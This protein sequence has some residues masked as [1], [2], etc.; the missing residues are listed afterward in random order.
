MKKLHSLL[1]FVAAAL[2]GLIQFAPL[3]AA[4]RCTVSDIEAWW[5]EAGRTVPSLAAVPQDANCSTSAPAWFNRFAAL[6][7]SQPV[8]S[9]SPNFSFAE[10]NIMTAFAV[11]N[12]EAY[13]R[14]GQTIQVC[15]TPGYEV[16][17]DTVVRYASEWEKYANIRFDFKRVGDC[18]PKGSDIRVSLEP[19]GSSWSYIGTSSAYWAR[20]GQITL[21]L[22]WLANP[23]QDAAWQRATIIHEFGHA[24]GLHHEQQN[25]NVKI[26][27]DPYKAYIYFARTNGW[28]PTD[29]DINVLN[30][31]KENVDATLWDEKSI[32]HYPISSWVTTNGFSVG[33]NTQLSEGDMLWAT[34]TYPPAG[35]TRNELWVAYDNF[36]RTNKRLPTRDQILNSTV[37][38]AREFN[39]AVRYGRIG[40]KEE[41]ELREYQLQLQTS[42]ELLS[43]V[44]KVAFS[45]PGRNQPIE[46]TKAR[47][48]AVGEFISFPETIASSLQI[49]VNA[50]ITM[51]NGQTVSLQK[52]VSL[53]WASSNPKTF[54]GTS[55]FQLQ[56]NHYYLGVGPKSVF[57]WVI[58]FTGDVS[59]IRKVT[60]DWTSDT[61]TK[62]S[63]EM[64][65]K[66]EQFLVEG[67][68]DRKR[69]VQV[70]IT[71]DYEDERPA[72]VVDYL[73]PASL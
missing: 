65:N 25:P 43:Q 48:K 7:D 60:Y 67:F 14:I 35:R 42:A 73:V 5:R 11:S 36:V 34:L 8:S 44:E 4:E 59:A 39:I 69:S 72:T 27:F 19:T 32:M 16:H 28:C 55:P 58:S 15:F 40:Y 46:V 38:D 1:P 18:A 53:A 70:K 3:S 9:D 51:A 12:S 26:P 2:S 21:N 33:R 13:W 37:P 17:R 30:P 22:G 57:S 50:T 68:K 63:K 23:N 54:P 61:G 41:S 56:Q 62:I 10:S 29:T 64:E 47:F 71:V 45:I 24:L 6:S 49:P 66:D 20:Q 52:T 31:L